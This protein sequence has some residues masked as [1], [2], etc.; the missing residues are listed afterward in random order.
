MTSLFRCLFV[1]ATCAVSMQAQSASGSPEVKPVISQKLTPMAPEDAAYAAKPNTGQ[2][3]IL[4]ILTVIGNDVLGLPCLDCLLNLLIPDLGLPVP[5]AKALKGSTY[6]ID[7]YL[8]DNNYNGSCTFNMELTDSQNNVVASVTQ[9]LQ[10]KAGNTILLS[11]PI[12]VPSV[13][14]IGLGQVSNKATCGSNVSQS[15]SPVVLACVNN[16]P[17][18]VE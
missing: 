14:E 1:I 10:E 15:K 8:I 11:A 3:P 7:S 2:P 9:T 18:C 16:P 6:Q 5:L 13:T 4:N 12:T 17:F